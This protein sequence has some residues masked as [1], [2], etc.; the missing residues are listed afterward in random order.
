MKYEDKYQEAVDYFYHLLKVDMKPTE[1]EIVPKEEN[2]FDYHLYVSY[3]FN[4]GV[5]M[6]EYLEPTIESLA[7]FINELKMIEVGTPRVGFIAE[8]KVFSCEDL[9]VRFTESFNAVKDKEQITLDVFVR[10]VGNY[11]RTI[12]H[13]PLHRKEMPFC[14]EPREG[15]SL[16]YHYLPP[17]HYTYWQEDGTRLPGL[18]DI[19]TEPNHYHGYQIKNGYCLYLGENL[20]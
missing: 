11:Y 18:E 19:L 6:A 20:Y 3:L 5:P 15:D 9:K 12:L 8:Q 13:G 14:T 17:K 2:P 1:E 16:V 4:P 7:R 10:H